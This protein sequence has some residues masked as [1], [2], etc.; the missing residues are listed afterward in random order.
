MKNRSFRTA[1]FI[2]VLLFCAV[3]FVISSYNDNFGQSQYETWLTQGTF[4][5]ANDSDGPLSSGAETDAWLVWDLFDVVD[6]DILSY[7]WDAWAYYGGG[8]E[9]Y[10]G[11]YEV[12]AVANGVRKH[13]KGD[14]Q[15]ELDVSRD[16][17]V[18]HSP[19]GDNDEEITI[20]ECNAKGFAKGK[21]PTTNEK[22]ETQSH[23]PFG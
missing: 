22:H 23:I 14:F 12:R 2:A 4:R 18:M 15:G 20:D 3:Q 6:G 1:I 16:V 8:N 11:S 17:Y 5:W 19:P 9:D 13:V 7:N 21:D 10:T